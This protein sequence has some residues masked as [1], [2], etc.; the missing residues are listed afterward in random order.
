[1]PPR[2]REEAVQHLYD[3]LA[4]G[5]RERE[6]G[7]EFDEHGVPDAAARKRGPG[8]IPEQGHPGGLRRQ[9]E[10]ARLDAA[11]VEQVR[12]QAA[13]VIG[14][15]VDEPEELEHLCPGCSRRGIEHARGQAP[16]Q[17][18]RLRSGPHQRS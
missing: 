18:V 13:H 16:R 14:V 6:A 11:H 4:V 10:R 7:R 17:A 8:P 15:P 2:V 3:V 12:D 5:H 9:G 1:M